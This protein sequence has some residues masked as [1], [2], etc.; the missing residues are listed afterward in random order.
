MLVFGRIGH[1]AT[2]AID[3]FNSASQPQAVGGD[4]ALQSLRCL[5][6]DSLES[7]IAQA[8]SG[9]TIG[10][11][12]RRDREPA[13]QRPPSLRFTH[14]VATGTLWAKHLRKK[15]PESDQRIEEPISAALSVSAKKRIGNELAQ[16]LAQLRNRIGA[17]GLSLQFFKFATRRSTKEQR[18]QSGEKR[19]RRV[20]HNYA[21]IYAHLESSLIL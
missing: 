10:A 6:V 14:G 12:V 20:V 11:G 9:L 17:Q 16:G 8:A 2:G 5:A 1:R 4:I 3:Y 19:S 18:K 21:Y 7:L 15:R 13:T